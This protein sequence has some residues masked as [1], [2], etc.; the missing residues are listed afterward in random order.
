[1][2]GWISKLR[3]LS[4][5]AFMV[6]I[7]SACGKENLTSLVPK[8]YGAE[9]SFNVMI[10][11]IL[12]M[13]IVFV[14]VMAIYLYVI[15][16]FRRKKGQ[17][18]DIPKQTEGN[19]TLETIWTII[20]IILLIVIAVPTITATYDLADTSDQEDAININVQGEQFWWHFEYANEG[21]Q[22]SQDL[23]IP[24]GE[25]VYLNMESTDV[26]H[27][28]WL[29]SISGKMDVNPENENSMYIEAYEEGVYWG[30][31]TE[32][33]G[34]SHS[35][36]DFKVIAVSPE[37]Y[38]QWVED[39]KGTSEQSTPETTTA[40]EGQELFSNNCLQCHATDAN[41]PSAG[42]NLANFGDRT[43]IAG[44]LDYNK[45]ELVNWITNPAEQKPANGMLDAPYLE[46]GH[47]GNEEAEKIADYLMQLQ[48]SEITPES[49]K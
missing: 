41:Q 37:E 32:F 26:I 24:T 49:A 29:P 5:F 35:L 1:M 34:S 40:Q 25:K 2:K 7:L 12:V 15:L 8:G 17:E 3:T 10:I 36:M 27:S 43:T 9:Q 45:E 30:K 19:K 13:I 4:L 38:N 46:E 42:P 16:R 21:L 31:C 23:Y 6:L 47:I 44:V 28:F 18:D 11:S 39:M 48:P 22:A 20:P 33:C 14:V